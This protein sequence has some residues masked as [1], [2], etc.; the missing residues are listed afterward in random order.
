MRLDVTDA[1]A[2]RAGG[3][4]VDAVVNA[5]NPAKYTTW[6]RDWP[7]MAQSVQAAVEAAGTRLVLVGNLYAYGRVDAPMT[8]RT[9]LRPNG[10]KG[11]LRQ[12]MW[13]DLAAAD[14]AGRLRAVELR[15]SDYYGPGVANGTSYLDQYVVKPAATRS[16]VRVVLGD[17]DVPHTWT[18]LDDIAALAATV[19][20]CEDD[21]VWGRA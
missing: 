21:D 19:A 10:H 3:A 2:T 8:E 16:T 1:D 14:R 18:H 6:D 9:P 11:A 17:P 20:V 4:G 7:P 13:E 15:A 12:R 5:M